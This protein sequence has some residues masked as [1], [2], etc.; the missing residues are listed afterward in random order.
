MKKEQVRE[1]NVSL[2]FSLV[3]CIILIIPSDFG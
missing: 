3:T 1:K 2:L